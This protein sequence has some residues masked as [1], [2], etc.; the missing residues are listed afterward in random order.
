MFLS[1]CLFRIN[2]YIYLY[3]YV[4]IYIGSTQEILNSTSGKLAAEEKG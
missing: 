1:F 3:T 4:H 2:I